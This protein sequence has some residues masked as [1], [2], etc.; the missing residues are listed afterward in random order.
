MENKQ[1]NTRALTAQVEIC[2]HFWE[3]DLVK[4]FNAA[5]ADRECSESEDYGTVET[6]I[7]TVEDNET[8]VEYLNDGGS[9]S[10]YDVEEY[11]QFCFDKGGV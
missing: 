5:L 2:A 8:I 6:F 1:K 3:S 4:W 9:F 10:H 11:L 7:N